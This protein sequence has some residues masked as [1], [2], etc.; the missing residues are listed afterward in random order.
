MGASSTGVS[1]GGSS[2]E[3]ASSAAPPSSSGPYGGRAAAS[4]GALTGGAVELLEGIAVGARADVPPMALAVD[5][6]LT[7][8]DVVDLQPSETVAFTPAGPAVQFGPSGTLFSIPARVTLPLDPN[9]PVM[10]FLS[11][12]HRNDLTQELS[13]LPALDP[14]A[15]TVSALTSSFSSFQAGWLAPVAV[16]QFTAEPAEVPHTGSTT[17]RW[18]AP[19]ATSCIL[20]FAQCVDSPETCGPPPV[21]VPARGTLQVTPNELAWWGGRLAPEMKLKCEGPGG[22]A[23]R[24][25]V[26]KAQPTAS[27]EAVFGFMLYTNEVTVPVGASMQFQSV[28]YSETDG[29]PATLTWNVGGVAQQPAVNMGFFPAT[30]STAGDFAVALT[31][32]NSIGTAVTRSMAVHV[33]AITALPLNAVCTPEDPFEQCDA[34]AHL[35]CMDGRCQDHCTDGFQDGNEVGLDCGGSCG[36][37]GTLLGG[38]FQDHPTGYVLLTD[39]FCASATQP[40]DHRIFARQDVAGVMTW[41]DARAACAALPPHPAGP[42]HVPTAEEWGGNNFQLEFGADRPLTGG[43]V[44]VSQ[45]NVATALPGMVAATYWSDT[46]YFAGQP[47]VVDFATGKASIVLASQSHRTRC[48]AWTDPPARCR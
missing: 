5:A 16:Q 20:G 34:T 11:V 22:P 40:M 6:V 28:C 18:N 17:L 43:A 15:T 31:C 25:T 1:G 41:A 44:D 45:P 4:V 7:V 47:V 30:F 39:D 13:V 37:C 33:L 23:E 21:T 29:Q 38:R 48:V 46:E 27:L 14:T 10:D 3:G 19:N 35:L 12:I 42:W 36:G 9:A 8:N 24:T 2:A 32:T 26:I